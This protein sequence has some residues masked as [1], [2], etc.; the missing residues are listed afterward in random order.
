MADV[1]TH[2]L[3]NEHLENSDEMSYEDG[4]EPKPKLRYILIGGIKAHL[5][6]LYGSE[7]EIN[8]RTF[9]VFL[10]KGN[11]RVIPG[12]R[13]RWDHQLHRHIT[14]NIQK[15]LMAHGIT[16][17]PF[18][19]HITAAHI[20]KNTSWDTAIAWCRKIADNLGNK[21]WSITLSSY[22]IHSVKIN[23]KLVEAIRHEIY[24]LQKSSRYTPGHI[25]VPSLIHVE[26]RPQLKENE[27]YVEVKEAWYDT[28]TRQV[29]FAGVVAEGCQS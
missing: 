21:T 3:R 24:K 1:E 10:K 20:C 11:F 28:N 5:R 17:K 23:G 6:A 12:P 2:T 18:D 4:S 9:I 13:W 29:H 26:L 19:T 15:Q 14:I 25:S 16:Y 8:K 22:G 7:V 27:K